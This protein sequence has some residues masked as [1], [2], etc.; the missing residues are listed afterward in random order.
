MHRPESRRGV[1]VTP[2]GGFIHS[3]ERGGLSRVHTCSLNCQQPLLC[4][5]QDGLR[6]PLCFLSLCVHAKISPQYSPGCSRLAPAGGCTRLSSLGDPEKQPVQ[7][8]AG[9]RPAQQG[10]F[11]GRQAEIFPIPKAKVGEQ[12]P[13]HPRQEAV[14]D[15]GGEISAAA[16]MPPQSPSGRCWKRRERNKSLPVQLLPSFSLAKC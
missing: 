13:P 6:L 15:P 16:R 4:F 14:C 9:D 2:S 12:Q 10:D 8:A 3:V 5:A 1:P 11:L 7:G